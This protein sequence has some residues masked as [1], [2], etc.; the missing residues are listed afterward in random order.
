MSASLVKAPK[1]PFRP[2]ASPAM[3][4]GT[5]LV[6]GVMLP[7][8]IPYGL[9]LGLHGN[10]V[11]LLFPV[12]VLGVSLALVSSRRWLYP[13]FI[14]AVFAYAA[15]LRRVADFSG[16]FVLFNLILVAP[17]IG[18]IPTVPA[19][20]RRVLGQRA[21]PVWPFAVFLFC[22]VYGIFAA[23]LRGAPLV[24]ALYDATR[25][26]LPICLCAFILDE[27]GHAESIR[28][29]LVAA[30]V[31][32]IPILTVYGVYQYVF[33][34][35]W[36][37]YWLINIGN[38]TFGLPEPY[39]I[40][41]FSMMNSPFSAAVFT[42]MA[43][44]MLA[45]E[46]LAGIVVAGLAIPMLALTLVRTAWFGLAIGLLGLLMLAPPQRKLLLL[47]GSLGLGFLCIGLLASPLLSPEAAN[48]VS[49]RVATFQDLKTDESGEG[50]LDVYATFYRRLADYPFGT[51]FGVNDS[52]MI[53]L[54][55]QAPG[56]NLDSGVLVTYLEFG[57]VVGS[58]FFVAYGSL[59]WQAIAVSRRMP[60]RLTG[61]GAVMIS[62]VAMSFLGAAQVGEVGVLQWA[63]L[64]ILL[65][66]GMAAEQRRARPALRDR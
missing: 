13:T 55:N 1:A 37:V 40:R 41:V 17:Y 61:C 23:L 62:V 65:A 64:S 46:G 19:M 5:A 39:K 24:T 48:S 36:D 18:L 31:L 59:I 58:A 60:G 63:A 42:V 16:G 26:L 54:A 3:A 53:A 66:S 8:V 47:L 20:A 2:A 52:P 27:P 7:L 9:V 45:A 51:G 44:L 4:L 35:Q 10:L 11:R 34:P 33:A 50:R 56:T 43:M 6:T 38:S 30:M 12:Y 57:I 32:V 14:I 15:F 29:N 22:I 28:R 25:W 49:D 21:G